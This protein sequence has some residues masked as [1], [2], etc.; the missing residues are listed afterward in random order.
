ML[1][2]QS[3]TKYAEKIKQADEP[4]VFHTGQYVEPNLFILVYVLTLCSCEDDKQG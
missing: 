1:F 3:V 2:L 4:K